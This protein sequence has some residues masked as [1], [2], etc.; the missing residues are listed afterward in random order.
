MGRGVVAGS[1]R[2]RAGGTQ[3]WAP[4]PRRCPARAQGKPHFPS[5]PRAPHGRGGVWERNPL[6]AGASRVALILSAKE[7]KKKRLIHTKNNPF[8]S[9]A[10][11]RPPPA[12]F[13]AAGPGAEPP[14]ASAQPPAAHDN[15][16]GGRW[17]SRSRARS[18]GVPAEP[19]PG[20][21]PAPRGS[22]P[23][24]REGGKRPAPGLEV[25]SRLKESSFPG[26]QREG[27]DS[28]PA[29]G[30]DRR[31]PRRGGDGRA[32]PEV[33]PEPRGG[34]RGLPAPPPAAGREAAAGA[35]LAVPGLAG[36]GGA[37]GPGIP[38]PCVE[39]PPL[40]LPRQL[41]PGRAGGGERGWKSPG[42][43]RGARRP[44]A[45]PR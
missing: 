8:S 40:P 45:P 7:R 32:A 12:R 10:P 36:V 35:E 14:P 2:A 1:M 6:G 23:D 16:N 21:F 25:L 37:P 4:P 43:G 29:G 11:P 24:L 22:P 15:N 38:P 27:G 5:P 18:R 3:G 44:P 9:R 17:S 31:Q 30:G 26:G 20:R 33:C 39:P 13:A 28:N 34:E 41:L 19:P 42:R